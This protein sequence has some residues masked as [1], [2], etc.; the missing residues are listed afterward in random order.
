MGVA[1]RTG[2]GKST[3]FLALYRIIEPSQGRIVIDGL[4][5]TTIGLYDLRSRLALVPQV[6]CLWAGLERLRLQRAAAR[7]CVTPA[8][9]CGPSHAA[10]L[11]ACPANT[12]PPHTPCAGPCRIFGH[13]PLQPGSLWGRRQR[14]PHL[15]GADAGARSLTT[16]RVDCVA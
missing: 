5:I 1:G 11:P 6:G 7:A 10:R 13:C 9:P 3:L 4:D 15:G 2:C 16:G 8:P 12:T 14:R